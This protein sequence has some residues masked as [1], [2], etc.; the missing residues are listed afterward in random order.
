MIA[1]NTLWKASRREPI[2]DLGGHGEQVCVKDNMACLVPQVDLDNGKH[3]IYKE[4]PMKKTLFNENWTVKPGVQDP[5][6]ALFGGAAQGKPVT[7][8]HDAMI[9]EDRDPKCEGGGQAGFYPAKSYTYTKTFT[10]PET[11]QGQRTLVE[12]E[13]VMQKAMT[14]LNGEFLGSRAYGYTGFTV[15]LTPYLR[16]GQENELKVLALGQEK[17][18]RWYSGMGIYRDVYLLQ[19]GGAYISAIK[20][21]TESIEEGYAVLRV[22]GIAVNQS[23]QPKTVELR[24]AI[25]GAAP[26]S[27]MLCLAPGESGFFQR[28]TVDSPEL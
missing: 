11:W 14:Y 8:P 17:A 9:E 24:I 15:D 19:G 5:F 18:S 6:S 20:I 26:L 4:A 1:N 12:F 27:A 2:L 23:T 28:I 7:L 22:D 13:G 25:D 16:Y 10:A 21:T 3:Q